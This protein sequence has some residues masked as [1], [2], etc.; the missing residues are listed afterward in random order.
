ME[1]PG[2]GSTCCYG[3]TPAKVTSWHVEQGGAPTEL[4][5]VE[6]LLVQGENC[7]LL[8]LGPVPSARTPQ[9]RLYGRRTRSRGSSR[10]RCHGRRSSSRRPR[11]Y[12]SC[13]RQTS[14]DLVKA[15][16]A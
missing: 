16:R 9:R 1:V 4:C 14:Q 13:Q 6:Y 2:S 8:H 10:C 11:P 12:A 3:R 5:P 15:A 7:P